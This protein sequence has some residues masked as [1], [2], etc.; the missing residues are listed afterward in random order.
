MYERTIICLA[1][2]RKPPSGRC[3]A[4][5]ELGGMRAGQWLRP[6]SARETR[7]VSEEER[8][9]E[10]GGRTQ[11]L[12]IVTMPLISH[13]P[14]GYQTENHILAED[15]YWTKLGTA[16]WSQV[17]THIDQYDANFWI[18]AESTYHGLND[19]V[20]EQI[21]A[22]IGS[23][24]KLIVPNNLRLQVVVDQGFEG[25]PSRRRLRAHF[26]YHHRSY[27]IIVTDPETEEHFLHQ[28][29][30][31]YPIETSVLCISLAEPQYGYASRLV[32]SVITP[33]RCEG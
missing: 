8:R 28:A 2:S 22:G 19:K 20:S 25:R 27:G 1:N 29:D 9:Y 21:A 16:T 10:T 14:L 12:D 24:L 17:S 30:G 6:V 26:D 4:G 7:E 3:I 31:Y 13:T 11:L 23:S 15:Y 5:K 32:A 18:Q 33:E